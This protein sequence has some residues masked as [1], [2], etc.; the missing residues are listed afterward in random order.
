MGALSEPAP[1]VVRYLARVFKYVQP[2]LEREANADAA[3]GMP[4]P[5]SK[6]SRGGGRRRGGESD[7][8]ADVERMWNPEC[9][10]AFGFR[11]QMRGRY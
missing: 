9:E 10:P 5:R 2:E 1:R 6:C 8:L 7:T 4:G 3:C 11:I